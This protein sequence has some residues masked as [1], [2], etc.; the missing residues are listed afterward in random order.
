MVPS[1][2]EEGLLK[3]HVQSCNKAVANK[4]VFPSFTSSLHARG[5]SHPFYKRLASKFTEIEERREN[6]TRPGA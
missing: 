6:E 3:R 5:E 1:Y 4:L 2:L